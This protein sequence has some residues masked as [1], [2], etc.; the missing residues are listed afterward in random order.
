[1][2]RPALL[3]SRPR[4][5]QYR[6]VQV[7]PPLREPPPVAQKADKLPDTR[8]IPQSGV[9][10]LSRSE[11]S[12][13]DRKE[14]SRHQM[15]TEQTSSQTNTRNVTDTLSRHSSSPERWLPGG[16]HAE[17]AGLL[18]HPPIKNPP[19]SLGARRRGGFRKG[20][21]CNS[22]LPSQYSVQ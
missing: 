7:P 9:P 21:R 4:G 2:G 15:G 11:I 19:F 13:Q 14:P 1:M 20:C 6:G 17:V 12:Q 5:P 10:A 8:R 16:N 3:G 18:P 22:C